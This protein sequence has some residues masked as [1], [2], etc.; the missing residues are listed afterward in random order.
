[1]PNQAPLPGRNHNPHQGLQEAAGARS[2]PLGPSS[3]KLS[4]SSSDYLGELMTEKYFPSDGKTVPRFQ[5]EAHEV[6]LAPEIPAYS[7]LFH[8]TDAF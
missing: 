8:V 4:P 2:R 5:W 3:P 6:P 1:M 7:P